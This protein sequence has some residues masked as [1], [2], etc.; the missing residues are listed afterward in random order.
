MG[1]SE[2]ARAKAI[3]IYLPLP[4]E[5]DISPV[6]LR[7]WQE[8]KIIAAPKLTWDKRHMLPIRIQSLEIG[9]TPTR[10]G[11]REPTDG[12]PIGI[13]A[14]DMVLVPALVFETEGNR[15][16]RGAGFYDR[17]LASPEFRGVSVGVAFEEQ[18]VDKLPVEPHDVPVD[19]L[20]TDE[21]L[22]RIKTVDNIHAG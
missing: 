1:T 13:E 4:D 16:G 18:V 11:V 12:E 7:G 20:I 15:I 21:R 8:E 10:A 17:F 2:F 5:V 14:L 9:I 19:I 3:M 6:A 22:I